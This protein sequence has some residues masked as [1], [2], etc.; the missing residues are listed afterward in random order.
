MPRPS[1]KEVLARVDEQVRL[2]HSDY[3]HLPRAVEADEILR[4]IWIEDTFHSTALEGNVLSRRQVARLL[5][6]GEASGPLKDSLEVEG[7]ARAARWVYEN[8]VGY[9]VGRGIPAAVVRQV[10]SLLVSAEWAINPPS[11]A[12]RPGDYR[13][14]GAT[15][16]GSSVKTSPPVAVAGAVQDW[17]DATA[18]G[19]DEGEHPIIHVARLHAW[20]ERIH[21][22]ADG[23]G[24]AGRLLLNFMLIQRGFPP[25]VLVTTERRRYLDALALS[26]RG[27]HSSLTELVAR[28]VESSINR[29][30]IPKLAGDARLMPL[31]ALA[32]GTEF[33]APYLRN[34]ARVG[35]LRATKERGIWLSSRVWLED[36]RRSRSP[37][38]RTSY[39]I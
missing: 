36:Y 11:D 16:A 17:L 3:G 9:D 15:I 33:K 1:G 24:R 13:R 5:E 8:A 4:N 7:Y 26:D 6:E 32:V 34:L 39:R 23:N 37:R 21:P 25:A 29:F 31:P 19:P 12:S 18:A 10:H 35:R 38:G 14:G 2:F 20:F 28:G 30:L 27:N 22:F